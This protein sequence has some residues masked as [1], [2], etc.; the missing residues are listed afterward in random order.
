MADTEDFSDTEV[1]AGLFTEPEGF[2][3][4]PDPETF[5]SYERDSKFVKAGEPS[6]IRVRLIGKSPLWGHLLWNAAKKTSA[7]LDEH[8]AELCAGKT[9]L[10][11]GAAAAIPS[12]IAG[13]T[14]RQVTITDYPDVPLI[15]NI[16]WNVAELG[17]QGLD[18]SRFAVE[19]YIWGN[20]TAD[21]RAHL[22]AGADGFDLV[23]LSDVV[24]NHTEHAKLLKTCVD[25]LSRTNKDAKVFVVFTPHRA[26]L[27]DRD[28][29]FF[30]DA[31]ALGFRV[32][33]LFQEHWWPMFDEEEETK[34]IRSRVYGYYLSWP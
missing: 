9:V 10:E 8:A 23:I 20:D 31:E 13:L 29:Q 14:A 28:L 21:V 6:T 2:F 4:A 30:A 25:T 19:P 3:K 16:R 1:D 33:K 32:E 7:W 34:E 15:D 18:A 11:L 22:P 27:L 24:F 12:F 5:D 17:K 26:R